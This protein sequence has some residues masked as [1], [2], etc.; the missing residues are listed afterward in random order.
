MGGLEL[1]G[2]EKFADLCATAECEYFYKDNNRLALYRLE[3]RVL[4]FDVNG[5]YFI[6]EMDGAN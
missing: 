6:L 5:T 4:V 3:E 2:L 1:I